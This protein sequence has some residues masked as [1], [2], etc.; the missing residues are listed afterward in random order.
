MKKMSSA[1]VVA[2]GERH[3]FGVE[4]RLSTKSRRA[5]C[6]K[7]GQAAC[8]VTEIYMYIYCKDGEMAFNVI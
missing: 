8:N 1:P 4:K 2:G 7:C 6:I 5:V 3:V